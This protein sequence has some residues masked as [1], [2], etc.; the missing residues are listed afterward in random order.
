[1]MAGA[2]RGDAGFDGF[3]GRIEIMVAARLV[4]TEAL[5]DKTLADALV[6]CITTSAL[7]TKK[8]RADNI[9]IDQIK[10]LLLEEQE[11]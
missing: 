2:Q 9:T 7:A 4:G 1:M 11:L 8:Q 10:Q 3:R 5:S 6:P